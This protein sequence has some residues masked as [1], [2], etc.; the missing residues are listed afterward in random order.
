MLKKAAFDISQ[1][2][3]DPQPSYRLV[4][5]HPRLRTQK[6]AKATRQRHFARA[7]RRVSSLLVLDTVLVAGSRTALQELRSGQATAALTEMLFPS[8]FMGGWGSVTAVVFGLL[9]AGAYASEQ[10]WASAGP[11]LKGVGLGAALAMWQSID[12]LGLAWTAGRWAMVTLA[13]GASL[14]AL[15]K[16][17]AVVVQHRLAAEPND[18]V[19][20]VGEPLSEPGRNVA[21]AVL[22]RPGVV[23]L[24]WLSEHGGTEDYLGHPSAVW[25]ALC[26]ADADTVV[27]AGDLPRAMFD[28]VVEAAAVAG[29]R[30]L[31]LRQSG[32]LTAS[33]PRTFPDTSVRVLELTF[34][35][36]RAGQDVAKRV[37]DSVAALFLLV[38]MSPL[39][40]VISIAIRR[41]S[42]GPILFSQERVGQAGRIFRMLKFRTMIDGADLDKA[43]LAHLNESG[44]TRLFKIPNDPRITSVGQVLRRWSL[45]EL[46]QFANVLLGHMS[47]VGPRPF[48]ESDLTDY[49]DHHFIRLSVKPGVTGLWQVG[50]RSSIVDFEQVVD[51]D[52]KYIEN[53]SFWLDLRILF[54]TLPAVVRRTGAY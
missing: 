52:R 22:S 47:L 30:V 17:L 21:R 45:D 11:I 2:L 24:G 14:L 3:P 42:P 27:L 10:R 44:D 16:L 7:V 36:S 20:F 39:L 35:A 23:S 33:R 48:F 53:W 43:D 4:E 31:A 5:D 51:L 9:L 25:D 12:S 8:G 6:R 1:T 38:A 54:L 18:R 13:L 32:T 40:L 41:G 34:P 50:G 28:S 26:Q 49:D 29:C 15:R 37:F 19:I 46:P